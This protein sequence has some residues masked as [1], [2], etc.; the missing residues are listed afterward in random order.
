MMEQLGLFA[1]TAHKHVKVCDWCHA[2]FEVVCHQQRKAK[3]CSRKCKDLAR[4]SI[5][6]QRLSCFRFESGDMSFEDSRAK[7][8]IRIK[9]GSP[10]CGIR[11][12][13]DL[14]KANPTSVKRWL[15]KAGLYYGDQR[16]GKAYTEKPTRSDLLIVKKTID[17]EKE[18]QNRHDLA[19]IMRLLR[20]N[21]SSMSVL[22]ACNASGINYRRVMKYGKR[23]KWF[24]KLRRQPEY[25]FKREYQYSGVRSSTFPNECDFQSH[26]ENR[27]KSLGLTVRSKLWQSNEYC[28]DIIVGNDV[29]IELKVETRAKCI[30][31]LVGQLMQA[32]ASFPTWHCIGV[33]PNDCKLT[34]SLVLSGGFKIMHEDEAV[35]WCE[36]LKLLDKGLGP[37]V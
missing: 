13:A 9:R 11:R 21:K 27:L 35:V 29:V 16:G 15:Q 22:Y 7:E 3:Y 25:K 5:R 28:P 20:K 32:K 26:F 18:R 37:I 10:K 14:V 19:I 30:Q 24:R 17:A 8:A 23:R 12:I 4:E 2:D 34:H 1:G 6:K 31:T 33:V 36:R